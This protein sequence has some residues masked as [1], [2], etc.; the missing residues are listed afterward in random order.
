MRNKRSR[1]K[2]VKKTEFL[3]AL[4]FCLFFSGCNPPSILTT[5]NG[6]FHLNQTQRMVFL[7]FGGNI[8]N[9]AKEASHAMET[10]FLNHFS[11]KGIQVTPSSPELNKIIGVAGVLNKEK[12]QQIGTHSQ[13]DAVISAS[14]S[15]CHDF[16]PDIGEG[17]IFLTVKVYN[18]KTGYLLL[19]INGKKISETSSESTSQM[20]AEIVDAMFEELDWK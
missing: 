16:N 19:I 8:T 5:W 9:C 14:V 13:A 3:I 4:F 15:E 1:E 18:G 6:P 17:A 20:T 12:V 10:T 7:H 2:K 11:R